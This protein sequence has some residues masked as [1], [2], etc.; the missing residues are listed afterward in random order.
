MSIELIFTAKTAITFFRIWLQVPVEILLSNG[1]S[2]DLLRIAQGGDMKG[3]SFDL[4]GFSAI[5]SDK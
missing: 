3:L 1:I 2:V 4:F 5:R